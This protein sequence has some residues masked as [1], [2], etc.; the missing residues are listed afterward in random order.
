MRKTVCCNIKHHT[1]K[2]MYDW[3]AMHINGLQRTNEQYTQQ[4][5]SVQSE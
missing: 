1:H 3:I 5:M 4:K 2:H